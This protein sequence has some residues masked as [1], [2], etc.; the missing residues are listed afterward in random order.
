[1]PGRRVPDS[2]HCGCRLGEDQLEDR[3]GLGRTGGVG[4]EA[5]DRER[6]QPGPGEPVLLRHALGL[7]SLP[8]ALAALERKT[9][10]R[11]AAVEMPFADAA[12]DVDKPADLALVEA[13]LRARE[14]A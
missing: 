11:L 14:G 4:Q 3:P 7:L 10:A 13:V 5:L 9:G 6:R 12:V 2:R 8:G 1:M